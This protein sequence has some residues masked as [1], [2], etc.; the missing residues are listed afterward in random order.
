MDTKTFE[1]QL[2]KVSLFA[3]ALALTATLFPV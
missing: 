2:I 1:R 3:L